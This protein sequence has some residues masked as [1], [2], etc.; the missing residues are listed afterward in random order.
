MLILHT[1]TYKLVQIMERIIKFLVYFLSS[2]AISSAIKRNK[3]TVDQHYGI[4]KTSIELVKGEIRDLG[5]TGK[6]KE[7]IYP[8]FLLSDYVNGT[9]SRPDEGIKINLFPAN[10]L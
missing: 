8:Y 4:N 3:T 6:T 2:L 5:G 1:T 7:R 10:F 9:I